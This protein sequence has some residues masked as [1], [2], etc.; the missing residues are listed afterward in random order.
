MSDSDH[1]IRISASGTARLLACIAVLLVLASV[2]TQYYRFASGHVT[3]YGLIDL[4]NVARENSLPTFFSSTTLFLASVLLGIVAVLK[5]KISAPYARHWAILAV[6]FLYLA[7]DEAASMHELWGRPTKELLGN[8]ATGAFFFSW[9]IPAMA[10]LAAFAIVFL[11][12][13]WH[14]PSRTRW[15]TLIA[16]LLYIGGAVG[17]EMIGARY[18]ETSGFDSLAYSMIA[19][20]EESLE[21]AG[22]ILFVFA[23]MEYIENNFAVLQIRF[24]STAEE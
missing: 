12:F 6:I 7:A 8:W 11:G 10:L 21:M 5:R 24:G 13:W 16:A 18:V 22:M 2:V 23:I 3:V 19:T 17:F 14:L 4:F 1:C 15:L 20:M 9:V